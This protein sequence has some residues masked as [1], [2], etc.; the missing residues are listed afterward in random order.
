ME[1]VDG[2]F[3]QGGFWKLKRKLIPRST[4]PPSAK[5]DDKGN[6][7][8]S[9]AA[10]KSLYSKTYKERLRQRDMR[11]EYMD[12][13]FLNSETFSRFLIVSGSLFQSSGHLNTKLLFKSVR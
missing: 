6:L 13:Y 8:T 2:K 3:S 10:L 12:I 11:A 1:N 7:I 9:S 5:L 4:D